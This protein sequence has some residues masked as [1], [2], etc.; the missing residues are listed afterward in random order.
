MPQPDEVD[1][2]E[3]VAAK[4]IVM[5]QHPT[6]IGKYEIH[7]YL[8][9]GMSRVYR[10]LDPVIDKTLTIKVLTDEG[11]ADEEAKARFLR[12]ARMAA[13]L[14]HENI[15]SVYEFGQDQG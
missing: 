6:R 11:C 9:G 2:V 13:K 8:G 1:E 5:Q 15:V 4:V 12:E 10:A 3:P 7:E 14:D